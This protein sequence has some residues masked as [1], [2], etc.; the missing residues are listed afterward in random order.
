MPHKVA[1]KAKAELWVQPQVE[2]GAGVAGVTVA[3]PSTVTQMSKLKSSREWRRGLKRGRVFSDSGG[4][5]PAATIFMF[6]PRGVG[7]G[8]VR[9]V[10][11]AGCAKTMA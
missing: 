3:N 5:C 8:G 9:K 6:S 10:G 7:V 1:L 4:Q 2:G 11:C